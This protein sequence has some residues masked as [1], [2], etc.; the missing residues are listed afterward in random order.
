MSNRLVEI[1]VDNW[2]ELRD[3]YRLNWPEH[4]CAYGVISNYWNWKPSE[5]EEP[6]SEVRIFSLNGSWRENGTFLLFVSICLAEVNERI[7]CIIVVA[8]SF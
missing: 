6:E 7:K 2:L 3:L 4:V 1:P 5:S 8:G